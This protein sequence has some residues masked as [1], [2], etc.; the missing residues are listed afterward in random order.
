[1]GKKLNYYKF[2][3]GNGTMPSDSGSTGDIIMPITEDRWPGDANGDGMMNLDDIM[4]M[5]D[6]YCGMT[7]DVVAANCDL[8]GDSVI[9]D[10]PDIMM[11]IDLYCNSF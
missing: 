9:C 10:L 5:I 8:D 2:T 11:T 3:V 1:M 7:S 4:L 6:Y